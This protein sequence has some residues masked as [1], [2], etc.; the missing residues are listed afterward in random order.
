M[1]MSTEHVKFLNI[2]TKISTNTP[3]SGQFSLEIKQT[4]AHKH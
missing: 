1:F 4:T 3:L 2:Q